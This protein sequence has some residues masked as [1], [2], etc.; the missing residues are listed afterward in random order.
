MEI[1]LPPQIEEMLNRKIESGLYHSASDAIA[2]ALLVLDD[3]EEWE[4]AN[5]DVEYVRKL[6]QEGAEDKRPSVSGQEFF[7]QLREEFAARNKALKQ[8]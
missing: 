5:E 7:A 1:H 4:A 8:V 2:M 6:I 3:Y